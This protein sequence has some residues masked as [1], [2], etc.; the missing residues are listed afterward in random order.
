MTS[1]QKLKAENAKLREHIHTLITK[2]GTAEE[3]LVRENYKMQYH[4]EDAV[5]QGSHESLPS[6]FH[7]LIPHI[8]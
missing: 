3:L 6:S 5:W 7:G 4:I 8:S 1:Y 2:R